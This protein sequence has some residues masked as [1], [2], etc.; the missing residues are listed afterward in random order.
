MD[1]LTR[2]NKRKRNCVAL[3]MEIAFR[4]VIK[5]T[6]PYPFLDRLST[7][8]RTCK[9]LDLYSEPSRSAS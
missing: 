2:D 3:S 8:N 1:M 7:K 4:F 9:T 6:A 5:R